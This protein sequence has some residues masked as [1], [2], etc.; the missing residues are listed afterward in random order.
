MEKQIFREKSVNKISS[1]EELNDYLR[2]TN[3]SV[4]VLLGA[5]ILLLVGFLVWGSYTYIDSVARGSGRVENGVMTIRFQEE[6][7]ALGVEAG[8]EVTVGD[9]AFAI[10]SVG[11]DK[12]G[13]LAVADTDLA[14]GSYEVEVRLRQTQV[15]RLLFR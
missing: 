7:L 13:L 4:W 6:E 12:Q 3:P 8:M 15:L 1:P 9:S 14:D 2:V 11:R 10:R 5:V